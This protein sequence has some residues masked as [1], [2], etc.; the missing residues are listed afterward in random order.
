MDD[1]ITVA[2]DNRVLVV[3]TSDWVV[4]ARCTTTTF[5]NLIAAA[6]NA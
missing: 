5:A 4:V 3:R 1:Y 2:E 6:L